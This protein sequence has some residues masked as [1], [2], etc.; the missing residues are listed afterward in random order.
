MQ[1]VSVGAVV[2]CGTGVPTEVTPQTVPFDPP[3]LPPAPPLL[4]PKPPPV[5]VVPAVPLVPAVPVV[6]PLQVSPA[7]RMTF[8][9]GESPPTTFTDFVPR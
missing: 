5:P 4:P 6:L 3:L 1:F 9:G 8:T 2:T 7:F